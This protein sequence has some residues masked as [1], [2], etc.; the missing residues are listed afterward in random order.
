MTGSL[1]GQ[2]SLV[3]WRVEEVFSVVRTAGFTGCNPRAVLLL[4]PSL[5]RPGAPHSSLYR[6]GYRQ[7]RYP[8]FM[9]PGFAMKRVAVVGSGISGSRWRVDSTAA[10]PSNGRL[11]FRGLRIYAARLWAGAA[12]GADWAASPPA[13]ELDCARSL[14]GVRIAE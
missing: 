1:S 14:D 2:P 6:Q 13:L 5:V 11:R 9:R 10:S 7:R 12:P 8:F 4:P 3:C